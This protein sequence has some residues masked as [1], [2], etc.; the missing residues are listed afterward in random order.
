MADATA[1]LL[2]KTETVCL[3]DVRCGGGCRN[4]SG[5]ESTQA[6]H[7]VFPYRGVY[8]RHAGGED[9]VAEA[10]QVL[11]FNAHEGYRV[12]HPVPGGDASLDLVIRESL[13]DELAPRSV[14]RRGGTF[15]FRVQRLRVD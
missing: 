1:R 9:A 15:A 10:N 14:V 4:R 11:F 13:L 12:S 3:R 8:V 7:L 5:E 2:L 6:T